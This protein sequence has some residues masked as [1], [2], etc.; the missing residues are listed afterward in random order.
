M[1]ESAQLLDRHRCGRATATGD[2][3]GGFGGFGLRLLG[4]CGCVFLGSSVSPKRVNRLVAARALAGL[5]A[6]TLFVFELLATSGR[7]HQALH[8]DGKPASSTC[9]ICLFAKGHL[10]VPPA[11]PV[12]AP[13]IE[14][15]WDSSPPI[16]SITMVDSRYLV[17]P[18]RAP[19]IL[20]AFLTDLA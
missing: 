15:S 14:I 16:E 17:S 2:R 12:P 6:A 18:P 13:A 7:F 19:P 1:N 3:F 10:D 20:I 5:L 4:R 11:L 8:C 9:L